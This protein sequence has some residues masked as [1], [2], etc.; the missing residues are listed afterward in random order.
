MCRWCAALDERSGVAS[1]DRDG[2]EVDAVLSE[3]A[4]R[5]DLGAVVARPDLEVQVRPGG[6]A[7][8]ADLGDL[9]ARLA[10]LA[11]DHVVGAQLAVD[12]DRAVRVPGRH[13]VAAAGGRAG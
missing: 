5:V 13:P 8:V 7:G 3:P 2:S 6:L 9:L 1:G 11:R 4:E 12:G 10:L